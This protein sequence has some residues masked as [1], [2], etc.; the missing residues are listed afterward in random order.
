MKFILF[1]NLPYSFA[2]LKPIE[3][4]IIK[5]GFEYIWYITESL[6]NIFPYKDSNYTTSI[7]DLKKFN[8]DAIFV[9]G[10]SVPHYLRGFKVQVFHGLAGEKKGHFRIRDYFDLY[11]TQGPYFTKKFKELSLKHKNF[12]VI[13]T[14]WSKL[15]SLFR[16]DKDNLEYKNSLINMFKVEKIV[17]YAPTFSPSLTS[18]SAIFEE[19]KK[20]SEKSNILTIIKFHDKMC[21][22]TISEYMKL[23]SKNLIISDENDITKLLQ[24]SDLM[25]SDTSSVVYEFALLNKS[26]ITFNSYSENIYWE[27]ITNKD[28]LLN[29]VEDTLFKNDKFKNSREYII[30]EYHPYIDGESSKRVIDVVVEYINKKEV[31]QKRDISILRKFKIYKDYGF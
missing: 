25:I 4:E 10:N 15:D 14:G 20:L 11:L 1:C 19:I 24:I 22:D 21:R 5:R 28:T 8:S 27:N 13:E 2:I 18:A 31:P 3:D 30:K 17:L 6:E 26:I 23:E 7:K 9:P 12:D 16:V 29:L